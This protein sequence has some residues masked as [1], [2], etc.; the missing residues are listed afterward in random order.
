MIKGVNIKIT[1]RIK[2]SLIRKSKSILYTCKRDTPKTQRFRNTKNKEISKWK[3]QES[4]P[5]TRQSRTKPKLLNETQK[6]IL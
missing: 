2:S 1:T 5:D 3:Q 6:N 4:N